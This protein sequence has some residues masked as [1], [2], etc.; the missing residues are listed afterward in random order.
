MRLG[1]LPLLQLDA[2]EQIK[3]GEVLRRALQD[4]TAGALGSRQVTPLVK[5]KRALK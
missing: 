5:V 3:R 1:K 2:A 4:R